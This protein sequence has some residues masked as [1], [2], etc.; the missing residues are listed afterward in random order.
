AAE[1]VIGEMDSVYSHWLTD[2]PGGFSDADL[3]TLRRLTPPLAL[4]I[5]SAALAR[6]IATLA[7]VYL[8][9]DAAQLV[10]QG[11]IRRGVAERIHAVL[12]F[13]DLRGYTTITDT[14]PPD[15]IIPLLN[16]YA[17]LVISAVCEAGG[18]VLKLM[19]DGTLAVFQANDP[20]VACRAALQAERTLRDRGSVLDAARRA[21]GRPVTSVY[22]GLHVGE[23]FFGNIGSRSRLDFTVVGPAVNE[24][25]RIAA[26]CRSVDR[27][28]LLSSE[29]VAAM[30][31]GERADLVSL[32]RFALRG[33]GRPRELFTLDPRLVAAGPLTEG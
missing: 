14:A 4:A 22:L 6:I 9:A 28:M 2:A 21:E 24:V 19:G 20:A 8:G 11:R 3:A 31:D 26:M 10:L 15:E 27:D 1:A 32:G 7:E 18:D 17:E 29:F 13:S 16:D 5:K 23:V 33:V 30:P 12:W 25:A